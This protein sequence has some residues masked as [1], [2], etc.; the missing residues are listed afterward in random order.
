MGLRC[1]EGLKA[2]AIVSTSSLSST[3]I[4]TPLFNILSFSASVSFRRTLPSVLQRGRERTANAAAQG[5]I[6]EECDLVRRLSASGIRSRSRAIMCGHAS[7]NGVRN[8]DLFV[9]ERVCWGL[10]GMRTHV[11][12]AGADMAYMRSIAY[13]CSSSNTK[14]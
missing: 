1:A 4:R 9:V 8:H 3:L 7:A 5:F 12:I 11:F 6:H 10:A 14:Q 2:S 13:A